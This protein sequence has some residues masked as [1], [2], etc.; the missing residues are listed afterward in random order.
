MT[1]SLCFIE[2]D[3]GILSSIVQGKLKTKSLSVAKS[4]VWRRHASLR[5]TVKVFH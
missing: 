4:D 3:S 2:Y 1:V 5:Q